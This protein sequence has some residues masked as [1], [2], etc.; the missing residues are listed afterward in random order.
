MSCTIKFFSSCIFLC[1]IFLSS[2]ATGFK[3]D[4]LYAQGKFFEA[5]I[6][7]ERMIFNSEDQSNIKNF[8]YKKAL[9]YKQLNNYGKAIEE[10]QPIYFPNKNDSLLLRVYYLQSLCYYL[11]EEPTQALW[12]IDE[13]LSLNH[14]TASQLTLLP[15]KVLCMNETLRWEEAQ[16]CLIHYFLIQNL[17]PEKSTEMQQVV[18]ELYSRKKLPHIRS[19]KK[20]EN[21]SRFIPGTGQIYAGKTG[22]GLLNF[23]INVSILAFSAQ[24]AYTGFY[25]TGYLAGLGFFNK[26]YHGGIKRSGNLATWKNKELTVTFNNKINKIIRSNLN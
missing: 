11:N 4:S 15:L 18:H 13:C 25:I 9:C 19:I 14:D 16:E 26:I 2:K 10:L 24:Q 7:Y 17:S 20:A 5:S 1:G 6:E 3:G 23:F 12:K 8:R 21:W 22:E